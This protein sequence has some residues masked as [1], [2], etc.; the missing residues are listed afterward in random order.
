MDQ[1]LVTNLLV[2]K[3]SEIVIDTFFSF[4]SEEDSNNSVK[5]VTRKTRRLVRKFSVFLRAIPYIG[6]FMIAFDI[7]LLIWDYFKSKKG[8]DFAREYIILKCFYTKIDNEASTIVLD[9]HMKR[10]DFY[11]I[12]TNDRCLI[13]SYNYKDYTYNIASIIGQNL[14]T[15]VFHILLNGTQDNYTTSLYN[16]EKTSNINQVQDRSNIAQVSSYPVANDITESSYFHHVQNL[17]LRSSSIVLMQTSMY[18]SII[19]NEMLMASYIKEDKPINL[20]KYTVIISNA[21]D[22]NDFRYKSQQHCFNL[23][24]NKQINKNIVCFYTCQKINIDIFIDKYNKHIKNIINDIIEYYYRIKSSKQNIYQFNFVSRQIFEQIFNI[25]NI[26]LYLYDCI[27]FMISFEQFKSKVY[28]NMIKLFVIN[29]SGNVLDQLVQIVMHY[30]AIYMSNSS[31]KDFKRVIEKVNNYFSYSN[32][33]YRRFLHAVWNFFG[34]MHDIDLLVDNYYIPPKDNDLQ[35]HIDDYKNTKLTELEEFFDDVYDDDSLLSFIKRNSVIKEICENIINTEYSLDF[36]NQQI[37]AKNNFEKNIQKTYTDD[38][39]NIILSYQEFLIKIIPDVSA[40]NDKDDV[41]NILHSDIDESF[42]KN[43]KMYLYQNI[44][45]KLPVTIIEIE[46]IYGDKKY[47][48]RI[49]EYI[50]IYIYI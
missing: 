41:L 25:A 38:F 14:F 19:V 6:W 20:N 2:K 23:I 42:I 43:L 10:D 40:G 47:Y 5:A 7:G 45:N 35:K 1:N 24:E 33:D 22:I 3:L 8:Y 11:K 46:R 48:D 31:N 37:T 36:Q 13:G 17:L 28:D 30:K 15:N 39:N 34:F 18:S 16:I 50:Y 9:Y 27:F 12:K 4:F 32:Y 26:D 49:C 44:E 21:Q 29:S